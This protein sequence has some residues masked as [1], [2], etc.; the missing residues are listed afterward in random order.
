[1]RNVGPYT[2]LTQ[3]GGQFLCLCA[4]VTKYQPFSP[5]IQPGDYR[6][7]I[8]KRADIIDDQ[9]GLSAGLPISNDRR[10]FARYQPVDQF[11]GIPDRTDASSARFQ[12]IIGAYALS[13]SAAAWRG[14]TS[15]M[16]GIKRRVTAGPTQRPRWRR[17][18]P[19]WVCG[20][21][22]RRLRRGS[23]GINSESLWLRAVRLD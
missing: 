4:A 1:M 11:S 20:A 8:L 10:W 12:S 2:Q 9:I 13:R 18:L 15:N 6:C 3:Q 16:R 21:T 14:I 22:W 7:R 19:A 17:G 5:G 23:G